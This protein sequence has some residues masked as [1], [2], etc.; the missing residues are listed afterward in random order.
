MELKGMIF[1]SK[2]IQQMK[3]VVPS[4][5]YS[6]ILERLGN[7]GQSECPFIPL[8]WLEM[9]THQ[10]RNSIYKIYCI[11]WKTATRWIAEYNIFPYL[12]TQSFWTLDVIP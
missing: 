7:I 4:Y 5:D 8:Q 9:A 11:F 2:V 6:S 12:P 10:V 1:A 3:E